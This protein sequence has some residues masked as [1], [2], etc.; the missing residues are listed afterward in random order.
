MFALGGAL[1][2]AAMA[3]L[4]RAHRSAGRTRQGGTFRIAVGAYASVDPAIS[5]G[6]VELA[7]CA[8]LVRY[9]D[10]PL[11]EGDRLVPE[12]A[13]GYPKV[14]RDGRTYTFRI[15]KDVRFSTGARV[16]AA[17][18]AY[19]IDRVLSPELQSPYGGFL[20]DIVGT[21]AVEDG[22]A[23]HVYGIRASGNKLSI[24]LTRP[25]G[26]FVA[27]LTYPAYCPVPTGLPIVPEGVNVPPPGSG[28][29]YIAN[30]SRD[31]QLV[32]KRNRFYR[33]DRPHHVAQFVVT[34]GGDDDTITRAIDRNQIDWGVGGN[35]PTEAAGD[36]GK[37]YG[38]GGPRFFVRPSGGAIFYL[39]LNTQRPLFRNNAA[40]RQAVNF[41][42]DRPALV[43]ARG[44]YWGTPSD[45]YLPLGMAGAPAGHL[46]PVKRPNLTKARSLARGHTRGRTAVLYARD[47]DYGTL[48]AQIVQRNL[49]AIGVRVTVKQF[50]FL[51]L[52]EKV[53]TRGEPFDLAFQ[54]WNAQ[55]VDPWWYINGLLDG[56]TIGK[57]KN[58][59]V[60]YFN[61]PRYNRQMARAARLT[62][63]RRYR[64]YRKL[65][66]ILAR[67]AAPLAVF[68]TPNVRL[69]VSKRVGC[70]IS[71]GYP[72]G[73]DLAPVCLK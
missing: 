18:F 32:L 13:A 54:G 38:V 57:Y 20:D 1:L 26:D 23:R 34:I 69:F 71:N 14:S 15:R 7:T 2:G 40:L 53:G 17:N 27:R 37:K 28:P 8:L 52:L 39:A 64:A 5:D 6:W 46:Y 42:L 63:A 12:V 58:S 73:L 66:L 56:R 36:L 44:P 19:A 41:A 25:V 50:P 51:V 3:G 65:A 30:W 35:V 4:N 60:S 55:W 67:D 70:V 11:P 21:R 9:A 61:V 47:N 24:R 22:K 31:R 49:K 33:G 10:K 62:G 48:Q 45:G 29:Y 16:T 72:V 59:N 68:G 43:R